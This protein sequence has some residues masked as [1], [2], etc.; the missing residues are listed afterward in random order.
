MGQNA[1]NRK[2][3]TAKFA[4]KISVTELITFLSSQKCRQRS[5]GYDRAEFESFLKL[6]ATVCF[7]MLVTF[8]KWF[9]DE[10][11]A[12]IDTAKNIASAFH[13]TKKCAGYA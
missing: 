10:M 4:T 13:L 12:F 2:S 11:L 5:K 9:L 7:Q 6:F 3:A 1:V 8:F